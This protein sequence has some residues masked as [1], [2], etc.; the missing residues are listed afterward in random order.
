MSAD[1]AAVM[2]VLH[3][4]VCGAVMPC[5]TVEALPPLLFDLCRR[6]NSFVE[7]AMTLSVQTKTVS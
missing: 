7:K 3:S 1:A 4:R 5:S 2:Q 6:S